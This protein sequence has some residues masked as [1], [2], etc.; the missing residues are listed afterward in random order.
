MEYPQLKRLEEIKSKFKARIEFPNA[1]VPEIKDLVPV[2][3]FLKNKSWTILIDDEYK[4]LTPGKTMINLFLFLRELELYEEADDFLVWCNFY[5]LEPSTSGLLDYYKDLG[6]TFTEISLILGEVD[7]CIA[8]LD[9]EL[10]TGVIDALI[11][12]D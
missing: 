9:Y 11:E 3:L 10:R 6:K 7:S 1:F 4:D 5:F 2:T 8:G 12:S